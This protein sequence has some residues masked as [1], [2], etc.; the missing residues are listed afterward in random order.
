MVLSSVKAKSRMGAFCGNV[1][2]G[3]RRSP[4]YTR[5]V[6]EC[7]SEFVRVCVCMCVCVRY[8]CMV[9][10][11]LCMCVVYVYVCMCVWCVCVCVFVCVSV[12]MCVDEGCKKVHSCR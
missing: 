6:C 3:T 9:Y 5:M 11:Y 2:K 12:Y 10:V 1:A 7:L 8:V 4:S